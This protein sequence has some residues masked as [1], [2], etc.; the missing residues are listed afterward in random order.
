MTNPHL[1]EILRL[2]LTERLQAIAEL[3]DSLEGQGEL[4][5]LSDEERAEL[6]HR[7]AEDEADPTPG[8]SWS[9]LRRKLEGG[10]AD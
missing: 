2:P 6:D 1:D 5:P 7:I 9:E 8:V 4:F 3:W 10:Q